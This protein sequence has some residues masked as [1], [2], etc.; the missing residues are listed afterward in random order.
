VY[1]QKNHKCVLLV[2]GIVHPKMVISLRFTH[3]QVILGVSAF[4]FQTD[5]I[6]VMLKNVLALPSFIMTVNGCFCFEVHPS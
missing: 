3:P 4:F 5:T 6:R 1:I 2:N